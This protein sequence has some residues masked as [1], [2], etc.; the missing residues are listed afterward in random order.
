MELKQILATLAVLGS[1]ASLACDSGDKTSEVNEVEKSAGK[2]ESKEAATAASKNGSEAKPDEFSEI[3][4][5][6]KT[7]QTHFKLNFSN[8]FSILN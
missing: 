1:G 7:T 5:Q 8:H 6:T 3:I 4:H 2:S